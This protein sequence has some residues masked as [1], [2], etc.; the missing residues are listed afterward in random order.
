MYL[1]VECVA[2]GL[3]V[4]EPITPASVSRVVA[5]RVCDA[6]EAWDLVA[7]RV[8]SYSCPRHNRARPFVPNEVGVVITDAAFGLP[9]HLSVTPFS[10]KVKNGGDPF[11][12][13]IW[14][15]NGPWLA[16][17]DVVRLRD[18]ASRW[19]KGDRFG[20]LERVFFNMLTLERHMVLGHHDTDGNRVTAVRMRIL[21]MEGIRRDG[22][23]LPREVKFHD[24]QEEELDLAFCGN[25]MLALLREDTA[26][27]RPLH[28]SCFGEVH[29]LRE[30]SIWDLTR[31]NHRVVAFL[32]TLATRVD[33]G[34]P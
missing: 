9:W 26:V 15:T 17:D 22:L 20:P 1:S 13:S 29:L 25:V 4:T 30:M 28:T 31:M 6:I 12:E 24:G 18:A 10:R 5:A 32:R 16:A 7:A 21:V 33:R 23:Q 14:C 11:H 19:N 2:R 34:C 8:G 3:T 27:S